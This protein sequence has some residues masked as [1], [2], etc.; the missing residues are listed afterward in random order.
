MTRPQ[1]PDHPGSAPAGRPSPKIVFFCRT[2]RR[3]LTPHLHKGRLA[4]RHAVELR[5][6]TVDHRALPVPVAEIDDPVFECDFCSAPDTR[7]V[8]R[9][10]DQLTHLRQVTTR[11]LDAGDYRDR[12]HAARARRTDT[13]PAL[14]A[15]WGERWAAC[16][17][18]A[19]LIEDRDLYGLIGRVV[20][21]LPTRH[22]RGRRLV[23]VRGELHGIY[24][25]LFATLTPGRGRITAEHPLGVWDTDPGQAPPTPPT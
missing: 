2:C 21:G 7:W 11:V 23:R 22:I 14:T 3:A 18:C 9:A 10:D 15:A 19:V 5:G 20:T 1:G 13:E 25:H 8:Y 17:P 16:E 6:G 4:Y 24:S 12:H